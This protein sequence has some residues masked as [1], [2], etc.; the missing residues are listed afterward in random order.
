MIYKGELLEK[1]PLLF[2]IDIDFHLPYR[3]GRENMRICLDFS[4]VICY[5]IVQ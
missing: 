5:N 3:W 1:L 2:L 4:F